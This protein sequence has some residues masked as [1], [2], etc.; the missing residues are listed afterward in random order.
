MPEE[1]WPSWST[2][3]R[4]S[5]VEIER[6][7]D[8]SAA[9]AIGPDGAGV[10]AQ[11]A[12]G[13]VTAPPSS[14]MKWEESLMEN[15]PTTSP[16]RQMPVHVEAAYKDAVDNIIFLKRQQ[17]VATNYAL[18]V[19]AAIFVISAE[20]FS[21][22]DFARNSLGIIAIATFLIHWYVIFVFQRAI[23]KFRSRLYWIYRTYF[24]V[25]EQTALDLPLG[26]RSSW[27]QLEV[28]AGLVLVSFVGFVLTAIYLWSVR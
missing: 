19:Y 11:L 8:P 6:V 14:V 25:E 22:T 17:W 28:A 16:E 23:D 2:G 3:L 5:A 4:K 27:A 15:R 13:H 12:K 10:C 9:D 1:N 20:Y 21:R 26:P 18:L 24:N 7:V